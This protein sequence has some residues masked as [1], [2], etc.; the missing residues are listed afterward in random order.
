MKNSVKAE[1][2]TSGRK[3]Y[4]FHFRKCDLI[5]L[6]KGIVI[7]PFFN[8]GKHKFYKEILFINVDSVAGIGKLKK[9]NLN[10]FGNDVYLEFGEASFT[11][12]NVEIRLKNLTE[13]EKKLINI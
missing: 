1:T 2:F 6:K 8:I 5:F 9:I 10:S 7:I 3:N 11:S 13:E 4:S 12:T